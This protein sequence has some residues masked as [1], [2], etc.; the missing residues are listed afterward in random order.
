M[1][2]RRRFSAD[3][4]AKVALEAIRG[5]RTITELATKYQLHP[6]Q[7]TKWKRQAIEKLDQRGRADNA[8]IKN[9]FDDRILGRHLSGLDHPCRQQSSPP[10]PIEKR[11]DVRSGRKRARQEIG[12]R[13]RILNRKVDADA[14]DRAHRMGGVPDR[15]QP[16]P[17]P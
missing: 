16:R 9:P 8:A 13:D 17:R 10:Y 1:K 2:T 7:I 12:G 5:E 3:F 14:P 11:I 15:Q 6:N 4:K